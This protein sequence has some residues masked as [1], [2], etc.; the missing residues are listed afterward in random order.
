MAT[1]SSKCQSSER[2]GSRPSDRPKRA[3]SIFPELRCLNRVVAARW[4]SGTREDAGSGHG[5]A[6]LGMRE[7]GR[8]CHIPNVF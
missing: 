4:C 7:E 1:T 8:R 6:G 5:G 3:S 2:N